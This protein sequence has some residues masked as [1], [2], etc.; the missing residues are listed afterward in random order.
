[1]P[2]ILYAIEFHTPLST[3]LH[4]PDRVFRLHGACIGCESS[5][6]NCLYIHFI[7]AI[8]FHTP[9]TTEMMW[10]HMPV[11]VCDF[12]GESIV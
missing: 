11:H 8:E 1:M 6:E 7:Y 3:C 4:I 5:Y 12:N 2:S 9:L 10:L